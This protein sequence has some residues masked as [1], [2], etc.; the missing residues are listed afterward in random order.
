MTT[1]VN[2]DM[3]HGLMALVAKMPS[4]TKADLDSLQVEVDG[5]TRGAAEETREA[6]NTFTLVIERS[7]NRKKIHT[8]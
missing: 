6:M 1:V 4:T 3:I 2:P 8:D 5:I 7:S